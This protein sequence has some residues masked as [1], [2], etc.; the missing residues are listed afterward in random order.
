NNGDGTFT[1]VTREAGVAAGRWSTVAAFFDADGD[2]K[3]DLYVG[4]YVR[5]TEKSK[6]FCETMGGMGSCNPSE[7]TSEPDILY[8][9]QGNGRFIDATAQAGIVDPNGRALGVLVDDYDGDGRPD[10]FVA[11]DGSS[12]YLFHNEGHGRFRNV[13]VEAGV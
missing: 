6:Q 8:L 5:F 3:L 9:N 13:G 2:G 1:D 4:R 11:N 12:D 7:Y 10:I